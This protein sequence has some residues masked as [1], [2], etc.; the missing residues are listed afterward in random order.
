MVEVGE[1][2]SIVQPTAPHSNGYVS[3]RCIN[4]KAKVIK[5]H[6]TCRPLCA[7]PNHPDLFNCGFVSVDGP[8]IPLGTNM[9]DARSPEI[10]VV[11][12]TPDRY[13]TIRNRRGRF[14]ENSD[15]SRVPSYLPY[16][17]QIQLVKIG[18]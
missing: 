6:F 16:R 8:I 18:E 14:T 9:N 13:D 1:L 10:S 5:Q 3:D 4:S 15:T 2:T 7:D 17:A 12:V 11:I